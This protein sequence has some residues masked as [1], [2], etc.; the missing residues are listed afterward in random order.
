MPLR[1]TTVTGF[2]I[3]PSTS[4]DKPFCHF[5]LKLRKSN[6]IS[7]TLTKYVINNIYHFSFL[8]LSPKTTAAPL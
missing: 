7:N 4:I 1:H 8:M 3:K 6:N 5:I 2:N